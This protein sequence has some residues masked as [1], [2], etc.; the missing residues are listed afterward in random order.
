MA[1]KGQRLEKRSSSVGVKVKT[2][3]VTAEAL[4]HEDSFPDTRCCGQAKVR[5]AHDDFAHF[6]LHR[7]YTAN[8]TLKDRANS[9]SKT[10]GSVMR[11]L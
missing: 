6:Q 9:I 10:R 7:G 5:N 4:D 8:A 3:F 1:K 2:Q 11:L